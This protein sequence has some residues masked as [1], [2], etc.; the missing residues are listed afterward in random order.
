M[1]S[2]MV[3]IGCDN[4]AVDLKEIISKYALSLGYKLEDVGCFTSEDATYYPYIAEKLCKEIEKS[5]FEKEGILICGTGIGMAITANKHPGIRAAV[6]HDNYSAE[7]AK[8]SNNCNVVCMGARF[9]GPESAK[10]I[11][12][13]WLSLEFVDG[14]STPKV[15]AIKE[16]EAEYFNGFQR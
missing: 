9:I 1:H 3:V 14:N 11:I 5:H 16:I 7:R 4:A 15:E 12:K 8:L 13:E 10:K 2:K 6:C